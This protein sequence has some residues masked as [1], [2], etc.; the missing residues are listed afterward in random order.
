MSEISRKVAVFNERIDRQGE[1]IRALS[2]TQARRAAALDDLLGILT[3]LK[4]PAE[5]LAAAAVAGQL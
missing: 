4:T 2:E 1:I 3:K 5:P